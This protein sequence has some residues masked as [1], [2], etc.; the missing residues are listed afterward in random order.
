MTG[1]GEMGAGA[2][3][4][5]IAGVQ[6]IKILSEEPRLWLTYIRQETI[7]SN[8]SD[9]T[10]KWTGDAKGYV[11][12]TDKLAAALGEGWRIEL[13]KTGSDKQLFSVMTTRSDNKM[14]LILRWDLLYPVGISPKGKETHLDKSGAHRAVS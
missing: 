3:G 13:H 7:K 1:F 4:V 10:I 5:F 2:G 6:L 11:P 12:D 8:Q 14:S 9:Q